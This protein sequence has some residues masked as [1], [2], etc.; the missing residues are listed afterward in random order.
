MTRLGLTIIGLAGLGVHLLN[1]P[2]I[3]VFL[4][5]GHMNTRELTLLRKSCE[6]TKLMNRPVFVL[7][8]VLVSILVHLIRRK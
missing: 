6:S 8:C 5:I 2:G 7:P 3:A 4:T 1:V